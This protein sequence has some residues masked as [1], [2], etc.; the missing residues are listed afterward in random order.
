[1][2][3]IKIETDKETLEKQRLLKEEIIEKE[4]DKDSFIEFCLSKKGIK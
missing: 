4:H 2:E 1:M 3:Y